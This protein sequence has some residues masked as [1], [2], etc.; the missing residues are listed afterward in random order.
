MHT[1]SV[2]SAQTLTSH[3]IRRCVSREKPI[4][5]HRIILIPVGIALLFAAASFA[6][7]VKTDYDHGADFS[8]YKTFSW[9]KVQIA[10]PVW[11]DR[12]KAAIAADLAKAGWRPVESG[13]DIAVLAL[14]IDET[15][16][17]LNTYYDAFGGTWSWKGGY[18]DFTTTIDTYQV[19]T[20]V[21]DLFDAN[22]KKLV[23][24]G[25]SSKSLSVKSDKNF[26]NLD[27]GVQKMFEHFP[28]AAKNKDQ[29]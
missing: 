23:W 5:G 16:Q 4:N 21:V 12:I 8:R 20:L 6:Q 19:G 27:K 9:E 2:A 1:I 18:T 24:R 15:H 13:G 11:A 3:P 17:T 7:E 10:D 22:T 29:R 28:P 25:S 14:E 26:E